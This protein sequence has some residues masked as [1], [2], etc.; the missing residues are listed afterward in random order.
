M[1]SLCHALRDASLPTA[2]TAR[3]IEEA[4]QLRAATYEVGLSGDPDQIVQGAKALWNAA[5]AHDASESVL[6][7]KAEL[8]AVCR[9]IAL[10]G[11]QHSIKSPWDDKTSVM[12]MEMSVRL[13]GAYRRLG[14]IGRFRLYMSKATEIMEELADKAILGPSVASHYHSAQSLYFAEAIIV[15][16]GNICRLLLRV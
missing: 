1:Q 14:D 13:A 2:Q 8:L 3:L 7:V 16:P 15:V 5:V 11:L 12:L 9:E 10:L 4:K 6:P